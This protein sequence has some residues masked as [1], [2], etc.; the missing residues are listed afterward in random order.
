M[1]RYIEKSDQFL[2]KKVQSFAD[3]VQDLVGL[4]PHTLAIVCMVLYLPIAVLHNYCAM[5]RLSE[6]K[7]FIV[8]IHIMLT[9][10]YLICSGAAV[11]KNVK[12]NTS[13]LIEIISSTVPGFRKNAVIISL[14]LI[15]ALLGTIPL[16][17]YRLAIELLLIMHILFSLSVYFSDS[18][19]KPPR[20]TKLKKFLESLK[21]SLTPAPPLVTT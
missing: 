19:P 8:P 5:Q 12:N 4:R 18:K 7:G 9:L 10:N 3:Y 13:I 16:H 6:M 2:L 20:K 1:I 17:G 14:F 11:L 15:T 21:E